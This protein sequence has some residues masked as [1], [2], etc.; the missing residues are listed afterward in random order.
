MTLA[1]IDFKSKTE[2]LRVTGRM[3]VEMLIA[4]IAFVTVLYG[5]LWPVGRLHLLNTDDVSLAADGIYNANAQ[6][7]FSW[8]ALC[9]LVLAVAMFVAGGYYGYRWYAAALFAGILYVWLTCVVFEFEIV[10]AMKRAGYILLAVLAALVLAVTTDKNSKVGPSSREDDKAKVF[11]WLSV[12][13][14]V[15]TAFATIWAVLDT[16]GCRLINWCH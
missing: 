7:M 14:L 2:A 9:S 13:M 10:A 5:P 6:R 8:V 15:L 12:A 4:V 16:A 1:G 3:V 11:A